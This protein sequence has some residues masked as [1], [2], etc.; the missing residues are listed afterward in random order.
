MRDRRTLS[1]QAV[2]LIR[3]MILEG[4]LPPGMPLRL[5]TLADRLGVSA[6]PV[7]EALRQLEAEGLVRY[8]PHRGAVVAELS[9][10]SVEELYT[11]RGALEG[12]AAACAARYLSNAQ[13]P[14]LESLIRPIAVAAR[15]GD[16]ERFLK[17]DRAFHEGVYQVARRPSLMARI[18]TLSQNTRRAGM[19]SYSDWK[20]EPGTGVEAHRRILQA[21]LAGDAR[22]AEELT[23]E[24]VRYG[25]ERVLRALDQLA[26]RR[27]REMRPQ[28]DADI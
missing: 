27:E 10:D 7:R 18:T 9:R 25:R 15:V 3:E 22:L 5:G 11:M 23:V 1:D 28:E 17:A 6:M 26:Q 19:L 20:A 21:V 24:H 4:L 13:R 2:S 12:L 14:L 8:R 16:L